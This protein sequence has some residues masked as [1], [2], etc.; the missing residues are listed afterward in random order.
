MGYLDGFLVTFRKLVRRSGRDPRVHEGRGRQAPEAGAL[1]RPPRAQPL[2]GRHGEVHRLRAVRRCLPRQAASTCA[3]PT[4]PP[5]DPV[6]PGRAVRLHL[7]DQLP[8][9]HPL[10]PVRRGLPD[11]GDH[12]D[13]AV[14]VLLHQPADAIYTKAELV[15]DDD[16]TPQ[17]LPWEDWSDAGDVVPHTSAWMRA[18]RPPAAAEYEGSVGLV[19]R[20]GLRR[21][22][23]RGGPDGRRRADARRRDA[24]L[25]STRACRTATTPTATTPTATPARRAH[26]R[27]RH[28]RVALMVE[29]I[30]FLVAG[31]ICLVGAVGVVRQQN[32]V[33]SALSLVARCSASPCCS[34][35]RRP[36]SWP[37]SR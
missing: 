13:E 14:R 28:P 34:S 15:V 23:A 11:R 32:P 1:P 7:R 4:T 10:R 9:V 27:R 30:V 21:A 5:D 22:P 8:A 35:P 19:G 33:H 25:S 12:R 20:A 37:P 17:Q 6:S 29:L 31:A 2:R 24:T 3:A 36:T 18:T 26:A 16:G